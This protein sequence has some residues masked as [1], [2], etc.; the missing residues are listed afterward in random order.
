[1]GRRMA[2]VSPVAISLARMSHLLDAQS[3]DEW[4]RDSQLSVRN[5]Q[6]QRRQAA[7][8]RASDDARTCLRVVLRVVAWTFENLAFGGP[9]PP[10]AAGVGTDRRVGDL[11][12]PLLVPWSAI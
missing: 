2:L 6:R 11:T 3:T 8:R 5:A 10:P 12:D 4:S 7:R 9:V 1:M